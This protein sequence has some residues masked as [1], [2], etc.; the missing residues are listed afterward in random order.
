MAGLY[1]IKKILIFLILHK[2]QEIVGIS[3][4]LS[5]EW[6]SL[7]GNREER[8]GVVRE[9]KWEKEKSKLKNC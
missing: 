8:K 7:F 3:K 2:S 6:V 5:I 9:E 4:P 1:A